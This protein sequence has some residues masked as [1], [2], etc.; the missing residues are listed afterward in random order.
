MTV[1]Q[2]NSITEHTKY[3]T[4]DLWAQQGV[5]VYRGSTVSDCLQNDGP[6]T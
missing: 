2:H 1:M 4:A 6:Q 5:T 3:P